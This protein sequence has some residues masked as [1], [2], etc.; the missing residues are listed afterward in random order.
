MYYTIIAKS[1]NNTQVLEIKDQN[2][3]SITSLSAN[4]SSNLGDYLYI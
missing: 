1:I 2:G 4:A 3:N